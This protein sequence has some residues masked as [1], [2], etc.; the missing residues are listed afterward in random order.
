MEEFWHG[1]VDFFK[2]AGL[3][4]L[5]GI[6]ILI[7]VL[8]TLFIAIKI[9]R[10]TTWVYYGVTDIIFIV[11]FLFGMDIL[12][13]VDSLFITAGSIIFCFSIESTGP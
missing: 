3:N 13:I 1:V 5:Y 6:I 8:I 12:T 11:A 9:N 2:N 7:V 10:P 4:I